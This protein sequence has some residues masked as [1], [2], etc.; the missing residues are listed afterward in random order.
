MSLLTAAPE[1]M[2]C[3]AGDLAQIGSA[4]GTA[5]AAAAAPTTALVAG[6][7]RLSYWPARQLDARSGLINS[8]KTGGFVPL[9]PTVY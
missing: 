3:A 8:T 7:A 6:A 5:H 1:F 2:T 9:T 4:L